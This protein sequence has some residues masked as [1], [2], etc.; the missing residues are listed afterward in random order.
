MVFICSTH[1]EIWYHVV[2]IW[3]VPHILTH[4]AFEKKW[5]KFFL[6][7]FPKFLGKNF[8][9][10]SY[11]SQ[12]KIYDL[13]KKNYFWKKIFWKIWKIFEKY[14]WPFFFKCIM[15]QHVWYDSNQNNMIPNVPMCRIYKHPFYGLIVIIIVILANQSIQD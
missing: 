1:R 6:K 4:Y 11:G 14:F 12:M 9:K 15:C 2:F 7:I 8:Q 13:W 3:V 10:F 5:S